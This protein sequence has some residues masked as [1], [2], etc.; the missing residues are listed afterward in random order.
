MLKHEDERSLFIYASL[1]KEIRV[2]PISISNVPHIL[3]RA[4]GSLRRVGYE[5]GWATSLADGLL[6]CARFIG[7]E[8]KTSFSH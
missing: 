4:I 8:Y 5:H 7:E 3:T 6:G 2:Q 1:N